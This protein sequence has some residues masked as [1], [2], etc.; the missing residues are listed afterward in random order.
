MEHLNSYTCSMS[1][2]RSSKK[3]CSVAVSEQGHCPEI[4]RRY[5]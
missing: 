1:Q 2:R 3:V 5:C 4:S